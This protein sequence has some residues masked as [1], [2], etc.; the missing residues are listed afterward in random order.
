MY[1][2]IYAATNQP[3]SD[4]HGGLKN[5]Q[6]TVGIIITLNSNNFKKIMHGLRTI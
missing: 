1:L 6:S 5:L 2:F 3:G 4:L